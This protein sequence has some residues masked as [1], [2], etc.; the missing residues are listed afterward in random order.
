[1]VKLIWTDHALEDLQNIADYIAEF[2]ERY[3]RLTVN[4]LFERAEVLKQF[5]KTG[6]IVPEKNDENVRGAN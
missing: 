6:R 2:S 1:M 5:P 3:A 4:S